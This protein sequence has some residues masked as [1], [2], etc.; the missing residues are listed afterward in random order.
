MDAKPKGGKSHRGPRRENRGNGGNRGGDGGEHGGGG[1][2]GRNRRGSRHG[3]NSRG[4]DVGTDADLPDSLTTLQP[5]PPPLPETGKPTN[6]VS[7]VVT[8]M[9]SEAVPSD[10][11]R[12]TDLNADGQIIDPILIETITHDLG[13]EHMMPVQAATIHELLPPTRA[14]GL[15]QAKTGTGKTIAFLLPAIQTMLNKKKELGSSRGGPST[16]QNNH[17]SLLVMAPTREL[18]MQIAKEAKNLLQ[19]MPTYHVCIA[20]GGTNKDREERE[21]LAGCDILVSTPGRMLDHLSGTPAIQDAL[22]QLDTLV[23]DEADRLLDMGFLPD[24]K[25]IVACLPDKVSSKRQGMLFSATVPSYVA[26]VASLVLSPGYRSISTIPKGEVSTHARVTQLLIEVPALADLAPA[27]VGAIRHEL[28]QQD[29]GTFKAI[30]FAQTAALADFYGYLLGSLSVMPQSWTLHARHAQSKRTNVTNAFRGAATGILVATDVVAR[31]MDFPAV[32][33][34]FQVGI[35][36]DK[37]SYIHRLGRT[38]R[39]AAGSDPSNAAGPDANS[40]VP[41]SGRG[42]FLVAAIEAYFPTRILREIKFVRTTPDLSCMDEL[43][44]IIDR[45]DEATVGKIYQAWLG[46]YNGHMKGLRWDRAMLVAAANE[47]ARDGLHAVSTPAIQKSTIG[48][49]G[50]RGTPGLVVVADAPRQHLGG[51]GGGGGGN[52]GGRRGGRGGRD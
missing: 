17:I 4:H 41:E 50:L 18:A 5:F 12:F 6:G 51:G 10:T 27:L 28:R 15:V 40:T 34:V 37:E 29:A 26:Q 19:R 25:K 39:G 23:L 48:K 33:T 13:F 2:G 47:F 7:G 9:L 38:A 46:Y 36:M 3:N 31:G 45:M 42:V 35:P 44:P 49:M 43:S 1:G 22:A 24:L 14:D 20:V 8:P 32:T 21:I 16:R 52:R 11:P 30:V